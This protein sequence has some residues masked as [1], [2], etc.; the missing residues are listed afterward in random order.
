MT[1]NEKILCLAMVFGNAHIRHDRPSLSIRHGEAQHSYL[2]W[3]KQILEK[4]LSK[5]ISIRRV[6]QH[7]NKIGFHL[8]VTHKFFRVLRERCYSSDRKPIYSAK[9]LEKLSAEAIAI[10][11]M[12]DGSLYAKKKDGKVHAYELVISMYCD[13]ISA[14][15]AICYFDKFHGIHFTIKRNKGLCSIRCGTTEARKFIALVRPFMFDG[16]LYKVAM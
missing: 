1:K 7:S 12:D 3:K 5:P 11:Y 2:M 6:E 4:G 8:E 16:L 15:N 9:M 13:E 14:Q 10:W